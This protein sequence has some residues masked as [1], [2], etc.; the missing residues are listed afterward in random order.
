MAF[1]EATE[2]GER[3]VEHF[4]ADNAFN[5]VKAHIDAQHNWDTM[6][7]PDRQADPFYIFKLS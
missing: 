4:K 3:V 2:Y 1:E 7:Q 5:D 6:F